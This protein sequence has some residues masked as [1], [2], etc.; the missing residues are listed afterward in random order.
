MKRLHLRTVV[1]RYHRTLE[2]RCEHNL[3]GVR[4]TAAASYWTDPLAWGFMS[5]F[6][7]LIS[8][9]GHAGDALTYVLNLQRQ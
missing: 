3:W 5:A 7:A 1:R 8:S 2:R 6:A 4:A 9:L